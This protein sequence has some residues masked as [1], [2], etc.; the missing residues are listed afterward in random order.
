MLNYP[1]HLKLLILFEIQTFIE[2]IENGLQFLVFLTY[3]KDKSATIVMYIYYN[4]FSVQFYFL[5]FMNILC[6]N[7]MSSIFNNR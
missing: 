7:I 1:I 4:M 3:A 2:N 5:R 6:L